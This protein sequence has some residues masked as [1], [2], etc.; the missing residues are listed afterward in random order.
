MTK[1]NS[2]HHRQKANEEELKE[3]L[4]KRCEWSN[5]FNQGRNITSWKILCQEE[6]DQ[7]QKITLSDTTTSRE[8]ALWRAIKRNEHP[9]RLKK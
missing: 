8:K 6:K 7:G 5:L 2:R 3:P 9:C 4:E 1:K